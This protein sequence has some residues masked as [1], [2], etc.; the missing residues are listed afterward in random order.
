MIANFSSGECTRRE[1][2]DECWSANGEPGTLRA[3]RAKSVTQKPT[4][5]AFKSTERRSTPQKV[6]LEVVETG[7]IAYKRRRRTRSTTQVMLSPTRGMAINTEREG[8]ARGFS[9]PGS[10]TK[11]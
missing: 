3:H 5:P 4:R 9:S 11:T 7:K 10:C 8:A 2:F 1:L 6:R